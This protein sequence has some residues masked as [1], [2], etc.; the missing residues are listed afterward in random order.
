MVNN[1]M[2]QMKEAV[3]LIHESIRNVDT[4][5]Q[6]LESK[7]E[8]NS[9]GLKVQNNEIETLKQQINR[10]NL[11]IVG[12]TDS[13]QETELEL[14]NKI[15]ELFGN[16]LEIKNRK[17]PIDTCYRMGRFDNNKNRNIIVKFYSESD[18]KVIMENRHHSKGKKLR[19]FLNEDLPPSIQ[20]KR[21]QLREEC[22][23]LRLQGKSAAVRG[24][25]LIMDN[26]KYTIEEEIAKQSST[27][28]TGFKSPSIMQWC[29]TT[30]VK[31]PP[32][33]TS[34]TTLTTTTVTP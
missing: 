33:S 34:A 12:V 20:L 22:S 14:Q 21:K 16:A 17:I 30:T 18:H 27:S 6:I 9:E 32:T 7:I 5:V 11:V 15:Q 28:F 1:E 13:Q 23:K 29:L 10:L 24:S 19:I 8:G 31:K 3:D 25:F 26:R 2:K 4:K